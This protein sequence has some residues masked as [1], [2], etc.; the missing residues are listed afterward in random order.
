M[1]HCPNCGVEVEENANF[2]SL[3]GERIL[4]KSTENADF[5]KS[6]KA[7]R[8][9]KLL[10]DYQRLTGYQ[11]RKIFWQISGLILISGII[12]IFIDFIGNRNIT[13]SRYPATIS[14]VLFIN[15][16]LNTFLRKKITLM[17]LLSFLSVAGLFI[18][19]DLYAGET[20]WKIKL[21]LPLLLALY[22]TLIA[23]IYLILSSKQKGLNI[24][25]WSL[26]AAGLISI[27]TEGMIS[28]YYRS[29]IYLEWSLIVMISALLISIL[30][31]YIHY[32]LKK[33]TDLKR[34]FHI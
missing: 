17:V 16:T 2:C 5:I 32:R 20:G 18:L 29:S 11:K 15:F 25:A 26:I 23:L 24:I 10:T 13:W 30:L 6:G 34:F 31:L 3:C 33:V 19:F 4:D 14:L 12:T 7:L 28:I 9:E 27:Y 21:G 8:E 1:A 22:T